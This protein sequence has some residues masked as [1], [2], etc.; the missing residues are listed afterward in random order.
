MVVDGG[1]KP[2]GAIDWI[3]TTNCNACDD[4]DATHF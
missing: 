2:F 3:F 1:Y 4:G